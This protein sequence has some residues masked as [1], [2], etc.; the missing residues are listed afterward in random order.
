MPDFEH[1]LINFG[2]LGVVVSAT[3]N[4]EP[5]YLVAKGIYTNLTFDSFFSNY[6]KI[7]TSADFFSLFCDWKEPR[8][9]S[10]WIGHRFKPD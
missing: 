8:M 4:M 7:M 9:N 2:A 10:V 1:Y 5:F 3:M 6:D